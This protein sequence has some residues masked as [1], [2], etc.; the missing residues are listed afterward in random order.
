MSLVLEFKL[1][2]EYILVI[3]LFFSYF[4]HDLLHLWRFSKAVLQGPS[5]DG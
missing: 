1:V 3:V 2:F 4:D 5:F